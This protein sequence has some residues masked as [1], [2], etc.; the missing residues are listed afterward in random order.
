MTKW[1][2]INWKDTRNGRLGRIFTWEPQREAPSAQS[3]TGE[4][5]QE[6]RD[7]STK[8]RLLPSHPLPWADGVNTVWHH[9]KTILPRESSFFIAIFTGCKENKG[10]SFLHF[11]RKTFLAL[12]E[13]HTEGQS[14]LILP[15][16]ASMSAYTRYRQDTQ[17][18]SPKGKHFLKQRT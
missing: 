7:F 10:L 4:C 6:V 17:D 12:V 16:Q 1:T 14:C 8:L 9:F 11:H 15:K 13:F 3:T 2:G 5:W 18:N